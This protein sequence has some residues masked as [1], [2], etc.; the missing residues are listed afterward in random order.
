MSDGASWKTRRIVV[1][2]LLASHLLC[3]AGFSLFQVADFEPFEFFNLL[4]LAGN[5]VIGAVLLRTGRDL[6]LGGAIMFLVGAHGFVG[7]F[8]APDSL[9]SGALLLVNVIVVY[10]GVKLN[11]EMPM[12]YW[13]AFVA[14]YFVLFRLF[15]IDV[16]N[17]EALFLLFLL[18]LA[19]TAR[20]FRMLA[21]F[22]AVTLSFTF[23]QPYAWEAAI[24]SL[25]V[26]NAVFKARGRVSSPTAVVFLLCGVSLLFLV[27]LPVVIVIFGEDLI[28]NIRKVIG[29]R[30][31][32]DAIRTTLVTA[33]ISTVILLFICV[34]LAYAVSRLRFPGR[35]LLLSL[36]D[37]PIVIPQSVAGIVLISVLGRRQL[38]G[39]ALFYAFGIGFDGT[40]LG[41]CAA[42]IFVAMPFIAKAAIAAFDAVPEHLELTA[43]TLGASSWSAFSRVALPLAGRGIFLGAIL[44]WARA[45]GEFGALIF[46]APTPATAPV[47]VYKLFQSVGA[48]ETGPVVA[49]L[50]LFSLVMFFLLQFVSR[51]M[52]SVHGRKE[53]AVEV[54]A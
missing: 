46:I 39:E 9:T 17:A 31:V 22:W 35:T 23:C 40:V 3:Y 45:A 20:S 21:C 34:P 52:P 11:T 41:I 43:R 14:S 24:L 37:V 33:S 30:D 5:F 4:L 13:I 16:E 25:F 53:A 28:H 6:W 1:L 38:I 15:I 2:L 10:V 8:L 18:G 49:A 29:D 48:A 26:L 7:R 36:I 12:R 42:Q 51:A 54:V 47:Q 27:L 50:L 32:L 19:A 44:A